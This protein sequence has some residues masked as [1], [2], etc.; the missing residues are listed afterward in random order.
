MLTDTQ[1]EPIA[2]HRSQW[3]TDSM[4]YYSARGL[5]IESRCGQLYLS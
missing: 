5:G 4:P 1:T 3:S 2:I